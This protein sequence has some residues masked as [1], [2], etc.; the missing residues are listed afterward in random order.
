MGQT[1]F[2]RPTKHLFQKFLHLLSG[3]T[4][5]AFFFDPI[6]VLQYACRS[7]FKAPRTEITNSSSFSRTPKFYF[8]Y[9]LS[10]KYVG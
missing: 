10:C 5:G 9:L 2:V 7:F 3:Q 6:K 4:N 1:Y 8:S